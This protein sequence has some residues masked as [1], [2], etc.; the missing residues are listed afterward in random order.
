VWD[1][2]GRVKAFL[3]QQENGDEEMGRFSNVAAVCVTVIGLLALSGC[4][5]DPAPGGTTS[6]E[7]D[8]GMTAVSGDAV[9]V[10]KDGPPNFEDPDRSAARARCEQRA[11]QL[12]EAVDPTT[13]ERPSWIRNPSALCQRCGDNTCYDR[14]VLCQECDRDGN[15]C[16]ELCRGGDETESCLFCPEDCGCGDGQVC[17][18]AAV[19]NPFMPVYEVLN[20]GAMCGVN[21][22]LIAKLPGQWVQVVPP[23]IGQSPVTVTTI[24]A[25]QPGCAWLGADRGDACVK[26][27][28]PIGVFILDGTALRADLGNTRAEGRV[29][30]EGEELRVEFTMCGR[31]VTCPSEPPY[32][33]VYVK[34]D[35]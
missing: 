6:G 25:G 5:S 12:N 20:H 15:G 27:F 18:S 17:W 11:E 19:L 21:N 22:P 8:G 23:N 34:I 32:S 3:S 16:N 29:I 10:A 1:G 33:T 4:G 28:S 7:V 13:I 30:E 2:G 9:A 26:G 35:D 14:S 31:G 24:P